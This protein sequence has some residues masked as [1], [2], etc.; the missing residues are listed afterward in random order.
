MAGGNLRCYSFSCTI[1]LI[2]MGFLPG[3][4]LTDSARLTGWQAPG[5][6][7]SQSPQLWDDKYM[8]PCQVDPKLQCSYMCGKLD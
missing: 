2:E 3:L 4:G 6:H 7:P 1:Y 5:V 8:P